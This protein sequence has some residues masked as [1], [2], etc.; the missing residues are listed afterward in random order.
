MRKCLTSNVAY[1]A[2]VI[3]ND[4]N[5][6]ES[7]VGHTEGDSY[8]RIYIHT[9]V[10]EVGCPLNGGKVKDQKGILGVT[11]VVLSQDSLA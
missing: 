5:H 10:H 8:R 9:A 1:Q 2:I 4:T 11:L 3:R 7:Y 6:S